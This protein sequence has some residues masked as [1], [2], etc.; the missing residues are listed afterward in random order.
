MYNATMI[1]NSPGHSGTFFHAAPSTAVESGPWGANVMVPEPLN[2]VVGADGAGAVV[3]MAGFAIAA[4]V[5]MF[6]GICVNASVQYQERRTHST[7]RRDYQGGLSQH[8]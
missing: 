1:D 5:T 7:L 2:V 8:R 3:V 4:S 6:Q